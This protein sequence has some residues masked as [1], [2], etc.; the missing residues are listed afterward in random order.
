MI[1][2]TNEKSGSPLTVLAVGAHPDDIEF[3][4]S[5]TLLRLHDSG[6]EL[7]VM[8][9]ADGSCGSKTKGPETIARIRED[10]ARSSASL[11]G[12]TYHP[13]LVGD[14]GIIYREDL[15]RKVT[16]VVRTVKP[17]CLLL[18]SPV[19]YMEDHQETARVCVTAAF[20]RG[21]PNY[22]SEPPIDAI[23]DPVAVYHA[24]PFGL[25]GPMG[26]RIESDF[27]IDVSGLES[28]RRR[29]LCEHASQR[30]WLDAS[31]GPGS[32]EQMLLRMSSEMADRYDIDGHAEGFRLRSHRGFRPEGWRPLESFLFAH[33]RRNQK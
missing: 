7:H 30:S 11:L 1:V 29:L 8:H 3:M 18:P 21:I 26:E 16:A 28:R 13:S 6:A 2:S 12:A 31:Q 14:I 5:G 22:A 17:G 33:V 32:Y 4:M 24:M 20:V 27:V 15:V 19:D 23:D 10:E 25:D 9:L